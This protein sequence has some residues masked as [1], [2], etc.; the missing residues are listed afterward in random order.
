MGK[1]RILFRDASTFFPQG[2]KCISKGFPHK[3]CRN[4]KKK[5][6]HRNVFLFHKNMWKI[7]GLRLC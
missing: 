7:T 5:S 2:M 1:S 6:I 3:Y 4:E